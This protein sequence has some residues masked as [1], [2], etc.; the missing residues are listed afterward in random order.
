MSRDGG[1]NAPEFDGM[2]KTSEETKQQLDPI[3][4][5]T[6]EEKTSE[7]EFEVDGRR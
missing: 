1:E 3:L 5:E 4:N 6:V 7:L 2:K